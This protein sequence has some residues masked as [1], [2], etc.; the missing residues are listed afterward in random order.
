VE[1][2]VEREESVIRARIQFRDG[3]DSTT[4]ERVVASADCSELG[5]SIQVIVEMA[6]ASERFE[7]PTVPLNETPPAS[8]TASI[9]AETSSAAI[10]RSER[11]VE[12]P[13]SAEP[14]PE[15][16]ASRVAA[17][18]GAGAA[19]SERGIA[20]QLMLGVEWARSPNSLELG[21]LADGTDTI[22]L[23][24]M[25]RIDV[26]RVQLSLAPCRHAG[27][28]AACAVGTIGLFDGAGRDLTRARHGY[29]LLAAAGFRIAWMQRV[30]GRLALR[31]HVEADALLTTT[32][33]KVDD[34]PVWKSPRFEA[35]TGIS[36]L[37]NF[38]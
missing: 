22:N 27:R 36:L 18:A 28:I 23:P 34:M 35:S 4:G 5:D 37:A 33:F 10:E 29:S 7:N 8:M 14:G 11:M 17:I 3:A 38:L 9:P 1:I 21:L 31:F 30:T 19:I 32:V 20:Q 6:L 24:V 2:D 16:S 13:D 12:T 15:R 25:G 26:S